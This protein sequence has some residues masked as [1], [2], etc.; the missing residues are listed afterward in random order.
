VAS[1]YHR[2]PVEPLV[3]PV[4][5]LHTIIIASDRR[6][7]SKSKIDRFR[8]AMFSFIVTL[9]SV[10]LTVPTMFIMFTLF[11]D[12]VVFVSRIHV[13]VKYSRSNCLFTAVIHTR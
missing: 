8:S 2:P 10:L 5:F 4:V 1:G 7:D 9:C 3:G 11:V 6:S 13:R 12:V